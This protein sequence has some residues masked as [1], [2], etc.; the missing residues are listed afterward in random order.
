[1]PEAEGASPFAPSWDPLALDREA[2]RAL[3]HRTVDAVVDLLTDPSTPCLRRAAPAEMS[4]LAQPSSPASGRGPL[5]CLP[6]PAPD[7]RSQAATTH[8][9]RRPDRR[10][11]G[12]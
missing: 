11:G 6:A 10:S 7:R 2:M 5:A 3:G 4:G 1:M 12:R 9:E 8:P